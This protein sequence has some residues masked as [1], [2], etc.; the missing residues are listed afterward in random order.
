MEKDVFAVKM[1]CV[2]KVSG[3]SSPDLTGDQGSR[4]TD[5]GSTAGSLRVTAL[6]KEHISF[7]IAPAD[8]FFP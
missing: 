6:G 4:W 2:L 8:C 3:C 5:R 7:T 1:P